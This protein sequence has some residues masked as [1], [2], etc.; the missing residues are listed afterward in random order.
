MLL[1]ILATLGFAA[2]F[3]MLLFDG[4]YAHAVGQVALSL[5]QNF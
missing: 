2:G 3:D 5:I 4:K 1:R